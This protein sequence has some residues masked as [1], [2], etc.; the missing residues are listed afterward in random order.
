MGNLII[1]RTK[2][3]PE[4]TFFKSGELTISGTS[5]S[6]NAL[7]F[8][9]PVLSWLEDFLSQKP[10]QVSITI[11][12][13][14]INTSCTTCLIKLLKLVTT[15]IP[16][17]SNLKVIWKFDPDDND[18]YEHGEIIQKIINHPVLLLAN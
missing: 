17:K 15:Q 7:E 16:D 14:Y 4:I 1:N 11:D 3:T 13:E 6:E 12:L 2:R 10:K 18:S 8:Y 5:I 9:T